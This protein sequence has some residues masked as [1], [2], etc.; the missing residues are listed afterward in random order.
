M[1]CVLATTQ[2][3]CSLAHGIVGSAAGNDT[4]Q[5]RI[6]APDHPWRGPG[7]THKFAFNPCLSSPSHTGFAN[8]NWKTP[9]P[10]SV[11]NKVK[12]TLVCFYYNGARRVAGKLDDISCGR[13]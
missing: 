8:T 9:G 13:G 10:L 12:L 2:R 4:W 5:A 6:V 1:N 11:E 7:R 3:Q